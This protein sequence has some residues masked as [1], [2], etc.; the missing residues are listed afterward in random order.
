LPPVDPAQAAQAAQPAAAPAP[1]AQPLVTAAPV[2]AAGQVPQVTPQTPVAP[3]GAAPQT[4][5]DD[6]SLLIADDADLIEKAWVEKAKQLVQQTK[7]DPYTQNKEINKFKADYIKKR[8]N[9][10]VQ[11]DN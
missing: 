9:K 3:A 8:Y 6:A 7:A 2:P 1:A 11:V 4:A 10:D 5:G